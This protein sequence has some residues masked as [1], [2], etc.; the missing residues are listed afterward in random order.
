MKKIAAASTVL[1]IAPNVAYAAENS[2]QVLILST[3]AMVLLVAVILIFQ[4]SASKEATNPTNG[5]FADQSSILYKL[6]NIIDQNATYKV[7]VYRQSGNIERVDGPLS[8]TNV[9]EK[10]LTAMRRAKITT[11]TISN[12]RDEIDVK[13]V[14]YNGRSRQEGKRIGGYLIKKIQSAN[15]VNEVSAI[16]LAD[17]RFL[18]ISASSES[19]VAIIKSWYRIEDQISSEIAKPINNF[20][21]GFDKKTGIGNNDISQVDFFLFLSIVDQYLAGEGKITA[22]ARAELSESDAPHHQSIFADSS[23]EKMRGIETFDVNPN[24]IQEKFI[25]WYSKLEHA[26][27]ITENRPLTLT[28]TL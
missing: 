14:I 19:E 21:Q 18:T 24:E 28:I 26:D 15:N 5:N 6:N 16:P 8:G 10:I 11:V 17:S 20:L 27:K 3:I 1:M 23:R 7:E 12:Y 25:E 2:P 4:I 22:L 13:R 9:S